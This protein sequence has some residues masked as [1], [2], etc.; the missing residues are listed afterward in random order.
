M[1]P[2]WY[3]GFSRGE[4][5]RCVYSH[6]RDGT[7]V[8]V[9]GDSIALKG[10]GKG[11]AFLK[12]H[13]KP[14]TCL[15]LSRSGLFLAS[16]DSRH[17]HEKCEV[18]VW[19]YEKREVVGR[20]KLHLGKV[21]HMDIS[22]D[23]QLL[24]SIGGRD[25]N[26]LAVFHI[27]SATLLCSGSVARGT[28]TGHALV[29]KTHFR[30]SS[31]FFAT[32]TRGLLVSWLFVKDSRQLRSKDV[33]LG[34]LQRDIASIAVHHVHGV[35]GDEF[36]YCGTQSGDI[37][38]FLLR[39]ESPSEPRTCH[40]LLALIGVRVGK[41][42]IQ[43][44]A[45]GVKSMAMMGEDRL[46]VGTGDGSLFVCREKLQQPQRKMHLIQVESFTVKGAITSLHANEEKR[47]VFLGT[48][49]A[50]IY[51]LS[52]DRGETT[53]LVT[54]HTAPVTCVSF[55]WE[56]SNGFLTCGKDLRLWDSSTGEVKF[57]FQ[58]PNMSCICATFSPLS[59]S[60]LFT[61]WSDGSIRVLDKVKGKLVF[62]L[63]SAHATS[64]SC[65]CSLSH[66]K[67]FITGAT[68]GYVSVWNLDAR[69]RLALESTSKIHR[70]TITYISVQDGNE[71]F[72]TS[73]LD[74]CAVIWETKGCQAMRVLRSDT[75]FT[76]AV[77]SGSSSE[78]LTCGHDGV[79][80]VWD[81]DEGIL[82]QETSLE[83]EALPLNALV[84][85]NPGGEYLA[86][87]VSKALRL[88]SW[89]GEVKREEKGCSGEILSMGISPSK[90]YFVVGCEDGSVFKWI[91]APS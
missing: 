9:Q 72:V 17:S 63:D 39:Q 49:S 14:V 7:L 13:R 23:D 25:D 54:G 83:G 28:Q 30:D 31:L 43:F 79:V 1:Q 78:V 84:V 81:C 76:C 4:V 69:R 55:P 86:A 44:F 8:Y 82:L 56:E 89:D 37:L 52:L 61:G 77:F 35:G 34:S 41:K 87:G 45:Q 36:I 12:A 10:G 68:N 11:S 38:K 3:A 40:F 21:Q 16:G 48:T 20:H 67:T 32:G 53:T 19:D 47:E 62:C 33:H 51:K 75:P 22:S 66:G 71:L 59:P 50:N 58:L 24:F 57:S 73:G 26:N 27:P 18:V 5:E 15:I 90:R 74:R 64:V 91:L 70:Q 80:R 85:V 2:S 46:L 65:I 6:G 88:V 42:E 60:L 29:V